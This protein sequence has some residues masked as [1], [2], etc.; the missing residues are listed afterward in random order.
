M[1]ENAKYQN[2]FGN[3]E[4]D[5]TKHVMIASSQMTELEL[6]VVV[7]KTNEELGSPGHEEVPI[8]PILEIQSEQEPGFDPILNTGHTDDQQST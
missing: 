2:Q 3:I 5:Q 4:S 6:P 8:I 7:D 1:D